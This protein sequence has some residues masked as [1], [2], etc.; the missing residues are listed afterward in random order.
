L[1][2]DEILQISFRLI[3]RLTRK[4]KYIA[5][6]SGEESKRFLKMKIYG[7]R[8]ESALSQTVQ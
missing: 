5:Y 3:A 7:G 4:K 1:I 6:F 2:F 8:A